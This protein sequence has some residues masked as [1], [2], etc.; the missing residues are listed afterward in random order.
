MP[1]FRCRKCD[2]VE[3]TALSNFWSARLRR[4]PTLC[5]ACDPKIAKWHGEF[6]RE[7]SSGWIAGEDG[8]LWRKQEVDDWLA[9]PIK[10][11]EAPSIG[12]FDA[13][14]ADCSAVTPTE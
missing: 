14:P 10:T 12:N 5:S 11:I 1:F 8:F 4:D 6:P 3:D 7:P 9:Q 13:E 2:H